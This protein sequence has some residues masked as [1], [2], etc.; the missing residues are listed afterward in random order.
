MQ[1]VPSPDGHGHGTPRPPGR[2]VTRDARG[3][4]RPRRRADRNSR[5]YRV[6]QHAAHF[7]RRALRCAARA[8]HRVSDTAALTV[9]NP[10]GAVFLSYSSED[11]AAAEKLANALGATGIEV[12]F[13]KSELRGGDAWDRR[14]REQIHD[15]RLF[16]PVISAQTEA[17]EEGYFRR[18]WRLAVERAGDM[19]EDRAFL[20]P[21]AIDG[22]NE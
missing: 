6:A 16:V 7:P 15:C 22:M 5:T 4:H 18:E 12:W 1:H 14:I 8:H 19:A 11:A 3:A 9:G 20:L 2:T 17:R 13:D 21:V 10:S